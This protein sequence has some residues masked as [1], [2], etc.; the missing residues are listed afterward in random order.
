MDQN[1]LKP[2]TILI[3]IV[4]VVYLA[5]HRIRNTA[6]DVKQTSR[7]LLVN[8]FSDPE[9]AAKRKALEET[10]LGSFRELEERRQAESKTK[11]KASLQRDLTLR[12]GAIGATPSRDEITILSKFPYANS[13]V[14]TAYSN[15]I[16]RTCRLLVP[17]IA[18]APPLVKPES[19]QGGT[20]GRLSVLTIGLEYDDSGPRELP[21]VTRGQVI[22]YFDDHRLAV[23]PM[24]YYD[25]ENR[26]YFGTDCQAAFFELDRPGLTVPA[27]PM[28]ETAIGRFRALGI[29][30][31]DRD[32]VNEDE[33]LGRTLALA[34][35]FV[36]TDPTISGE[37]DRP[38]TTTELLL[39]HLTPT[40]TADNP[41][42]QV[43]VTSDDRANLHRLETDGLQLNAGLPT[44]S[45]DVQF[46]KTVLM[47]MYPADPV[48]SGI[49][50]R[51][52]GILST[53]T[54]RRLSQT[55][56]DKP[57]VSLTEILDR[58]GSLAGASSSD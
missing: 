28:I 4:L 2:A 16:D 21:A 53:D 7:S 23:Q 55:E 40:C 51:S 27:E 42:V 15:A 11:N 29:V 32:D 47:G 43:F 50:F 19:G 14:R 33:I 8:E 31:A 52:A 17:G 6:P 26:P 37:A 22:Q 3:L 20:L 24:L 30:G 57:T 10:T 54:L 38:I 1:F 9:A 36:K 12:I 39:L 44:I 56:E 13:E 25:T 34:F 46:N 45:A 48:V 49:H 35:T 41:E 5:I 18:V 58:F